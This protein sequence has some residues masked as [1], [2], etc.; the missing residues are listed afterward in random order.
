MPYEVAP[1]PFEPLSGGITA[2]HAMGG[3]QTDERGRSDMN[4][5]TREHLKID[6][7]SGT[8]LTTRPPGV[9]SAP[10]IAGRPAPWWRTLA[11]LLRECHAR[12]RQRRDLQMLDEH[13]LKDVGLS[14]ADVEGEVRK[15]PWMP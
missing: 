5:I 14:H 3:F 2:W 1:L 4:A 15:W 9:T 11:R 6:R 7:I 12:S 13:Q 10:F 8:W